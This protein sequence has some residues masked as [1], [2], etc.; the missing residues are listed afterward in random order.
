MNQ[1]GY[2]HTL[3]LVQDKRGWQIAIDF[4]SQVK[5][6]LFELSDKSPGVVSIT[7]KES[8]NWLLYSLIGNRSIFTSHLGK[9]YEGEINPKVIPKD[10]Q[11]MRNISVHHTSEFE[12]LNKRHTELIE[13][14]GNGNLPLETR[15]LVEIAFTVYSSLNQAVINYQNRLSTRYKY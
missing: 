2:F 14:L 1:R 9:D 15:R 10:S 12:R 7:A 11:L 13:L 6:L 8:P 3:N 5:E 4:E